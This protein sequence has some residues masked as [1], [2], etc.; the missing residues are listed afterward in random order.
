[1]RLQRECT[2]ESVTVNANELLGAGGEARILSVVS[3][4]SIVAK[5]YHRP[6]PT[7]ALK[8]SAMLANPPDD[9]MADQSHISIAWPIDRLTAASPDRRFVGYI[10]P[11]VTGALP[12]FQYYNPASRRKHAPLFTYQYLLR[13]ARNLAAAVHALHNRGYVIGDMNES[14][15]LVTSTA[16]VTLVDT[17]SF[18]VPD[19][20]SAALYRCTVGKPE[21]TPPEIQGVSFSQVDRKSEHDLFGLATLLFQLLMEGTH[22][23]AG[24]FLSAGDPP[25]YYDRISSGH[26]PY[27]ARTSPYRPANAAPP[28]SLLNP[29][30]RSL[31]LRCFDDG[32]RNPGA[33][34][35]AQ[36]W[37]TALHE[38]E[39][40]LQVCSINSQHSYGRHLA[41]CPWC[42]RKLLLAGRD[43]FPSRAELESELYRA[44]HAPG[45]GYV[46][47]TIAGSTARALQSK[48]AM[49]ISSG[50]AAAQPAPRQLQP[51]TFRL[52][53]TSSWSWCTLVLTVLSV[54]AYQFGAPW[55]AVACAAASTAS[56]LTA[57]A[58]RSSRRGAWLAVL[59]MPITLLTAI[60][61]GIDIRAIR[62]PAAVRVIS[63]V[64]GVRT[65]AFS[66]DGRTIVTG[67]NRA[68]DQRL[69]GGEVQAWDL[70]TGHLVQTLAQYSGSVAS[71]TFTPNARSIAVASYGPM[72]A[73]HVD[74]IDARYPDVKT[75]VETAPPGQPTEALSWD[76]HTIAVGSLNGSIDLLD[77]QTQQLQRHV[78][79]KGEVLALA[80]SPSG[81]SIA[82]ATGSPPG[83][84]VS[85]AVTVFN[86]ASGA[87]E[88]SA[89]CHGNAVLAVAY[90]PN[91]AS[92]ASGGND[93]WLRV[94]NA[95]SGKLIQQHEVPTIRISTMAFSPNGKLLATALEPDALASL[96]YNVVVFDFI[97]WKKL[98]TL[99]GHRA[100]VTCVSFSPDGRTL[101]SGGLDA[102]LRLWRL[103]ASIGR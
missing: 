93:S 10:M 103:N 100:R 58:V 101:G 96:S 85:G 32:N 70:Q 81:K 3:H 5:I 95:V 79:V 74:L 17:D 59:S 46:A 20:G 87:L 90:S 67:T 22:P 13:A 56:A 41:S 60:D 36:M 45:V 21:Y 19:F 4:P 27:G 6:G 98:Q 94:W 88:W 65:A 29:T 99:V 97:A 11:R 15:I 53:T 25:P 26:F 23:F 62:S 73:G 91:G 33:R 24:E 83:S 69:I 75:P 76:G 1:M 42:A 63:T 71:L 72:G 57:V 52:P 28:I 80:F 7:Q 78:T 50:V 2:G 18:Q 16:L 34:P 51:L 61:S 64:S 48:S 14:N 77:I 40:Q 66:P 92:I 49:S 43:P 38:A 9:P 84:I 55:A 12:V 8:L 37:L 102:T 39:Q 82:V 89:P 54:G 47:N 30:L 44:A 31:M 35:D 68:E 86:T